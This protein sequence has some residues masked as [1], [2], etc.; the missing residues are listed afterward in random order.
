MPTPGLT[1][2][3]AVVAVATHRNFRAAA[4]EL[5]MSPSALS[6]AVAALEGRLGV[7]LFHRTTRSVSLSE[8]GEQFLE[9]VRPALRDIAE[10]MEVAGDF[11]HTPAGTLR[12]SASEV[13][14]RLVM[15]PFIL[16]FVR[17]YPDMHVDLVTDGRLID[18]TAEGFDAGIRLAEAVPRDMVAVPCSPDQRFVVV[19]SS[20]YFGQRPRPQVPTDLLDH[21]CVRWRLPSGTPYRW[22]F[23]RR[24]EKL[25]L[26]VRG[27]LTLDQ[28][29]LMI[30][31]ALAGLVL[32]YVKDWAVAG[33]LAAGRL[34]SV[35]DEW[36]APFPGLCLYYPRHR[37]VPAGLRAFVALVREANARRAISSHSLPAGS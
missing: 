23:E 16:D 9:R 11:R 29:P 13:G 8:A 15:A 18:I 4:T 17:R 25:N 3:N 27:P 10:A 37:H 7:R 1:E 32:A 34:V 20:A 22:E 24:G 21:P 28:Q 2:L 33:H 19:G 12:I 6:H 35:L 5:G 30:E 36:T 31:A 14:A 26:D